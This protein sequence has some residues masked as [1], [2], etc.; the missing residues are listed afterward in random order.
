MPNVRLIGALAGVFLVLPACHKGEDV[1][2]QGNSIAIDE[3][4]PT[5]QVAGNADIE[6][7]PADESSATPSNQLQ[8]GFDNP[9]VNDVSTS[10]P[11]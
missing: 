11:Q 6:T 1:N 3:G 4:V 7:L 5:N 2:A 8:N 9:D 10:K